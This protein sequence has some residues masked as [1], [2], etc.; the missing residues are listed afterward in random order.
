VHNVG[1]FYEYF[2]QK[3][4]KIEHNYVYWP[5]YLHASLF[6]GEVSLEKLPE[7]KAKR[8]SSEL[9]KDYS[10]FYSDFVDYIKSI[11]YIRGLSIHDYLTEFSYL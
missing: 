7:D 5:E 1:N 3:G 8:L 10:I 6:K 9:S 2:T 4:F 11:D